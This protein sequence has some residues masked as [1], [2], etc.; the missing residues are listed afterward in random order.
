MSPMNS[1]WPYGI[2][3]AAIACERL[4]EL[5]ISRRHTKRAFEAGGVEAG[6][7]HYPWMVVLHT[8]FLIACPL[9]VLLLAR[10]FRLPLAL[11][12][13]GLLVASMALRYW[14]IATLGE[15]WTTRVIWVPGR[16]IAVQGPF[17]WMRHPNYVAVI[18]EMLALP[19]VHGAWLT[20]VVFSGANACLLRV[21]M[22]AEERLLCRHGEYVGRL[23]SKPWF[24]P[25][26]VG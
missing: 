21:R 23:A 18:V 1:L 5:R 24:L 10:P 25:R 14:T 19:L 26:S 11:S 4:V 2:L 17:G 3:V 7:G 8:C 20:A 22:K 15:R 12:M 9:E 16:E 6:A 13:L